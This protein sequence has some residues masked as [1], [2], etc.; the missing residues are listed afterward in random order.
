MVIGFVERRLY[1]KRRSP[2]QTVFVV[3][4][5]PY[6]EKHIMNQ[7]KTAM[8][9]VLS[10]LLAGSMASAQQNAATPTPAGQNV[11]IPYTIYGNA[12]DTGDR[13]FA[14]SGWMGNTESLSYNDACKETPHKGETCI[15]ISF[16]RTDGWAGIVWQ[17]PANNWGD[18]GGGVNLTGAKQ[19]SFWAR[20]EKGGEVV[21]FKMGLIKRDKPYFDTGTATLSNVALTREWKQYVLPLAGVNLSR[22]ITGFSFS[23]AASKE[24]ITFYLDDIVYE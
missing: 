2:L 14:P 7:K 5:K 13:L 17:N 16:T 9:L 6:L 18:D 15:R 21:A 1:R 12:S 11:M 23:L 19:L 4:R 3:R 24:P 22:I 10:A 8:V 20:G